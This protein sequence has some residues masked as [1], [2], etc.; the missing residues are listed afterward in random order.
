MNQ[1]ALAR[2]Q[3]L[4]NPSDYLAVEDFVRTHHEAVYR[5]A[6]SVL[7]DPAEADDAAQEALVAALRALPTYRG[8]A[9]FSTWLYTITLNVC[10]GRL[11]KRKRAERLFETLR[12]IFHLRAEAQPAPEEAAI[13]NE[14][15]A[16]VRQAVNALDEK[17]RLPVILRYY[18][19]LPTAEIAHILGLNEGTVHSRLFNARAKLGAALAHLAPS[20]EDD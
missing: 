7:D 15:L 14:T 12:A 5:L 10:R 6:F 2:V 13:H 18:H 4:F 19:D 8:E 1:P 9:A 20:P 3:A 11:R 17:H 16:R